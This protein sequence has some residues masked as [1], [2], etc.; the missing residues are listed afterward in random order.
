M[1]YQ[2]DSMIDRHDV[3]HPKEEPEVNRILS[4]EQ[5][6]RN[7]QQRQQQQQ[8][9]QQKQLQRQQKQLQQQQK[10][11]QQ[12]PPSSPTQPQ[13][14]QQ[15][16]L[17]Q[18]SI[19]HDDN[20]H[21]NDAN[22]HN[23]DLFKLIHNK[24]KRRPH[25]PYYIDDIKEMIDF[26]SPDWIHSSQVTTIHH[27]KIIGNNEQQ[28]QQQ[29]QQQQFYYDG[30]MYGLKDFPGFYFFPS[31]ISDELQELL[32]Y[33]ALTVYCEAP[34]CTNIKVTDHCH[35]Q[36]TKTMWQIY[37][38][39]YYQTNIQ[40]HHQ[41]ISHENSTNMNSNSTNDNNK[42]DDKLVLNDDD[43]GENDENGQ[44]K[45][46]KT[47][48]NK[49]LKESLS[50]H[51]NNQKKRPK[52]QKQR[53]NNKQHQ[54]HFS[55][56]SWATMG[57]HYDWTKRS[58]DHNIKSKIP[59]E[60]N[61]LSQYFAL[62]SL[63]LSSSSFASS[64]TISSC[65][66]D[67][68]SLVSYEP[69]ACIVNYYHSKSVMGGHRDDLEDRMDKPIV[70]ISLGNSCVF[71]LGN[72]NKYTYPVK[73]ILLRSGDVVIL[74]NE[75]RLSYHSMARIIPS[76]CHIQHNNIDDTKNGTKITPSTYDHNP[77][78]IHDIFHQHNRPDDIS[79]IP[80][81]DKDA[82]KAFMKQHRININLRQVY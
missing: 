40:H 78:D 1:S 71:I 60:L 8:Q 31:A 45:S 44:T 20:N 7:D 5:Q 32:A 10:Q 42:K 14:E 4:Q 52:H 39:E 48:D 30:P 50:N 19:L 18:E 22:H 16:K 51:N 34:H 54:R 76:S 56:L 73:P 61:T 55:K 69:S 43:D 77:I 21:T 72:T 68:H 11:Q 49:R 53:M 67:F 35:Y 2:E 58:Y 62:P 28:Q 63:L 36:S 26:H 27:R 64:T 23:I 46:V 33:R 37:K 3:C 74:S 38:E 15:Q 70:S 66:H 6:P 17:I 75:S 47:I 29:Q 41:N 25:E 13:Q 9:Q 24:Y 80:M 59:Y 57:Y 81:E 65:H 12:S 82:F 79:Y